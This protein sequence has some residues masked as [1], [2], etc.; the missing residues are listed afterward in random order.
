VIGGKWK[1]LIVLNSVTG[2]KR[3]SGIVR[4]LPGISERMLVKQLRELERDGIIT[5]TVYAEVP[6]KVEYALTESGKKMM[7]VLRLLSLW[8]ATWLGR[9]IVGDG[10]PVGTWG[11]PARLRLLLNDIDTLRDEIDKMLKNR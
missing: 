1:P 7:P 3:Y 4:K 5:R 10:P 2:L 8:S 11:D 9:D 6:P